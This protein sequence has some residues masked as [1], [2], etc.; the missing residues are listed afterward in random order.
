MPIP[1]PLYPHNIATLG[2]CPVENQRRVFTAIFAG[3]LSPVI[4][5][6]S[7]LTKEAD[8]EG[9]SRARAE[10]VK[11]GRESKTLSNLVNLRAGEF[12][13]RQ[14]RERGRQEYPCREILAGILPA[15]GRE[16]RAGMRL[17]RGTITEDLGCLMARWRPTIVTSR[18]GRGGGSDG[19][20]DQ[21]AVR[22]RGTRRRKGEKGGRERDGDR[23]S[24]TDKPRGE[25]EGKSQMGRQRVKGERE[26]RREH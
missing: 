10:G 20:G 19:E 5:T 3:P 26:G 25:K 6:T 21:R 18:L 15:E 13:R 17:Y 22:G 16:S 14:R 11:A 4:V 23:E 7:T 24:E 12:A 9:E 8:G 1:R 2:P